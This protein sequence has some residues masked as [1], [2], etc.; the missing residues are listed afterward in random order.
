MAFLQPAPAVVGPVSLTALVG[1]IV[2]VHFGLNV[3]ILGSVSDK[4][5]IVSGVEISST[6]QYALG[7]FCL[8]GLPLTVH[9][10]VGAVYRVPGHLHTYLWYLFAFLAAGA[11]C[12][13]SV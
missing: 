7:A 2:L 11:A 13:I 9:G 4:S 3:F 5:V 8:L 6:L 10:G 1:L 12:L